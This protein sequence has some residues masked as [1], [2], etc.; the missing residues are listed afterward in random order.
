[1]EVRMR[2]GSGE[3]RYKFLM[4]DVDRHGNNR[5]YFRRK[6]QPKIRLQSVPGSAEFDAEYQLAF[7]GEVITRTSTKRGPAAP[8]TFRWLVEQ[9]YASGTYRALDVQTQ[10]VR[11]R[12][13]GSIVER[14]GADRFA[15]IEPRDV[16]K[17]RDEKIDAPHAGNKIV[18]ILRQ[19]FAWACDEEQDIAISNPAEKVKK[20]ATANPDGWQ[21]WTDEQVEQYC[22]YWPLGTMERLAIDLLL[23]TGA[24]R[25]DII[26]LGPQNIRDGKLLVWT[27]FK[28]RAQNAKEHALPIMPPLQASIDATAGKGDMVFLMKSR[29]VSPFGDK[30]GH[31]F[32]AWFRKR[33]EAAGLKGI[34]AHGIRKHDAVRM[35]EGGASDQELM[36][37]FGWNQPSMTA[38]YTRKANRAKMTAKVAPLLAR[39][40]A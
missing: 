24:R 9:Y 16:A 39:Q 25:S 12:V 27:E 2:D 28:G 29:P 40:R 6:G 8:Q 38:I 26:R 10:D 32:S 19:L 3:R 13:L 36:A 5:V 37:F 21:T 22:N 1:M 15:M 14:I 34:S 4:L 31:D 17:L 23:Y 7:S 33:V 30:H 35:A 11:K 18:T 20:L